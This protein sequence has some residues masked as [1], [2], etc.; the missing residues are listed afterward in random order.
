M[1]VASPLTFTHAQGAKRRFACSPLMDTSVGVEGTDE[2]FNMSEEGPSFTNSFKR[3]RRFSNDG[4]DASFPVPS[5]PFSS[6]EGT[7]SSTSF[8]P[9]PFAPAGLKKSPFGSSSSNRKRDYHQEV[10]GV[11]Q[12]L[13]RVIDQQHAEMERL[14]SEKAAV[15]ASYELLKR[16]HEKI[17]NE[18]RILKRA[19]TIQQERQNLAASEIEA[20]RRYGQEADQKSKRLEQMNLTLQYHLQAQQTPSNDFMNFNQR[21]PD[22]F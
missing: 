15:D 3:R 21:P 7:T 2:D 22:V 9:A 5:N 4:N 1:E 20:A 8:L 18:N 17:S 10:D 16:D 14:K 11:K 6:H 12:D 19:V 13:Q